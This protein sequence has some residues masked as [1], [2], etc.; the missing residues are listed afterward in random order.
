VPHITKH[1][2]PLGKLSDAVDG[3]RGNAFQNVPKVQVRI[4]SIQAARAD[5][6][7]QARGGVPA[8]I[9][10]GKQIIAPLMEGRA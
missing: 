7:V 5:Q 6:A 3:V 8:G 2:K 1:L 9:G 10:A 4:D